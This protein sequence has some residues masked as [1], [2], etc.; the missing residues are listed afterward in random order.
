MDKKLFDMDDIEIH[1][2][3]GCGNFIILDTLKETLA[4][5]N[6]KPEEIVLV[7]GIG[8]AAKISHFIKTNFFNGLH[9]RSLPVA[10]AIKAVNPELKVIVESGDGCTYGEGGNHLIHAI[11]RN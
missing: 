5:L 2:C 11:R 6:L 4:E 7:T 9:G 10:M 3:P 1:W 8:Q